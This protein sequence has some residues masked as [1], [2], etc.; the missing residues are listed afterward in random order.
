MGVTADEG[1][2][3]QDSVTYRIGGQKEFAPG[4][5]LGGSLGYAHGQTKEADGITGFQGDSYEGS[6]AIKYQAGPWM[7]ALSGS[8]GNSSQDNIRAL[9]IGDYY[10]Q[11]L[12]KARVITAGAR[13]RGAYEFA[14]ANWYVRPY[15]DLDALHVRTPFVAEHGAEGFNLN[16]YGTRKTVLS[17]SLNPEIGGRFDLANGYWLRPYGSVGF[18]LLSDDNL[19]TRVSFQGVPTEFFSTFSTTSRIPDRL[20]DLGLGLQVSPGSGLEFTAEYQSQLGK[21]YISQG[22]AARL[23]WR[24]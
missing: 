2:F 24:F 1:G 13:L 22:G 5:F 14:F 10:D 3:R 15:L 18:T 19:V 4:W 23:S 8:L 11:A 9:A 20:L 21:D 6:V 16:T 7:F 12:S 17:V